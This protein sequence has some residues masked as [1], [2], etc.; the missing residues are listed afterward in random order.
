VGRAM[1][2]VRR[3]VGGGGGVK[4]NGRQEAGGVCGATDVEGGK[5]GVRATE[6][7]TRGVLWCHRV[8]HTALVGRGAHMGEDRA[9]AAGW[10]TWVMEVFRVTAGGAGDVPL[11]LTRGA[12]GAA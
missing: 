8:E 11:G 6:S 12:E 7:W 9:Q 1:E 5:R 4:R 3:S 2:G 10:L